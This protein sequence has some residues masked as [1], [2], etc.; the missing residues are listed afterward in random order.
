MIL[1]PKCLGSI[2]LTASVVVVWLFVA[3]SDT[4]AQP[5]PLASTKVGDQTLEL[6]AV[7]KKPF[8]LDGRQPYL[9]FAD[10]ELMQQL[11]KEVGII[12]WEETRRRGQRDEWVLGFVLRNQDGS[13]PSSNLAVA[14]AYRARLDAGEECNYWPGLADGVVQEVNTY[15][16]PYSLAPMVLEVPQGASTLTSIEGVILETPGIE[17]SFE[18]SID[19]IGQA[20]AW[21]PGVV[22][23]PNGF[24]RVRDDWR[25]ELTIFREQSKPV[26]TNRNSTKQSESIR[27]RL[28]SMKPEPSIDFFAIPP[29]GSRKSANAMEAITLGSSSEKQLVANARRVLPKLIEDKQVPADR[30]SFLMKNNGAKIDAVRVAFFRIGEMDKLQIRLWIPFS[31]P[32]LHRFEM[33]DVALR[34]AGELQQINDFVKQ[35]KLQPTA[36]TVEARTWQDASGKFS[37]EAKFISYDG[38][39]VRLEKAD[40]SQISVPSSKLSKADIEYLDSRN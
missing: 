33:K 8:G 11:N 4:L 1:R 21:A 24:E 38:I 22:V 12:P 19:D 9:I 28:S 40:G 37:I 17:T 27:E 26:R 29:D 35:F 23:I 30:V 20:A 7:I 39:T 25:L 36:P 18:F 13:I 5:A 32:V 31:G 6:H 34:P 10:K 3:A 15:P 16:W 2:L 14:S